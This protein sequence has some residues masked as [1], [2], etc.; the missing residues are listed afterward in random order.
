MPLM[1]ADR[2]NTANGQMEMS[3]EVTAQSSKSL[4]CPSSSPPPLLPPLP[5]LSSFSLQAAYELEIHSFFLIVSSLST[6]N[7]HLLM[8]IVFFLPLSPVPHTINCSAIVKAAV[9]FGVLLLLPESAVV[10]PLAATRQSTIK[11]WRTTLN[12]KHKPDQRVSV[13]VFFLCWSA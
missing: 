9:G 5:L 11:Q 8:T 4:A 2:C 13:C 1:S 6:F 12:N 3:Q 7:H 10:A